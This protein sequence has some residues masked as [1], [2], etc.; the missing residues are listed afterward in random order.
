MRNEASAKG[1]VRAEISHCET[2]SILVDWAGVAWRCRHC[3]LADRVQWDE[4]RL[5]R[6]GRRPQPDRL[7]GPLIAR[8]CQEFDLVLVAGRADRWSWRHP[9]TPC[10]RQ[11]SRRRDA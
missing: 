4:G 7:L 5:H 9:G 10:P 2:T 3:L 6:P 1:L 8:P 11:H